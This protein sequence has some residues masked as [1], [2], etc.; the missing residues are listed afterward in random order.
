MSIKNRFAIALYLAVVGTS[1]AWAQTTLA[2]IGTVASTLL[3]FDRTTSQVQTTE[4]PG[5]HSTAVIFHVAFATSVTVVCS[6]P[7]ADAL[8]TSAHWKI[9]QI[10]RA[11][12]KITGPIVPGWVYLSDCKFEPDGN[13]PYRAVRPWPSH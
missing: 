11:T 7:D 2:D 9:G 12:G 8:A 13:P 1:S 3:S 10:M 4:N 5:P 6:M